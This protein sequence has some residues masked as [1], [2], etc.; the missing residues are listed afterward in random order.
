MEKIFSS[1]RERRQFLFLIVA[2]LALILLLR[3][4]VF[5]K[6][7][8]LTI[9][10]NVLSISDKLFTSLITTVIVGWFV[11]W[12][13]YEEIKK[14]VELIRSTRL[15]EEKLESL[16]RDTNQYYFSGGTGSYTRT[17][18]LPK[19]NELSYSNKS[20]ISVS[21]IL[22][23]PN[24]ELLCNTY[25]SYK[26]SLEGFNKWNNI[27]VRSKIFASILSI[28]KYKMNSNFLEVNIYL[29]DFF[30]L[31]RIEISQNGIVISKEDKELPILYLDKSS[32]LYSPYVEDFRQVV[33]QSKLITIKNEF[34]FDLDKIN[35]FDLVE[36]TKFFDDLSID[37]PNQTE[38]TKIIEILKKNENPFPI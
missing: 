21:I 34:Q 35:I 16:R 2:L 12:I 28:Y 36:I 10:E 33:K 31:L 1:I 38:L 30:S 14:K 23:N 37:P 15:I 19:L 26:N 3:I 18:T 24:N 6:I 20:S 22:M 13:S 4:Y 29:K 8:N 32:Y 27:E 25:S 9:K 17:V 7:D 11:F 5:P